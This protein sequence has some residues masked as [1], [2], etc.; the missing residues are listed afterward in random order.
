[1]YSTLP[2]FEVQISKGKLTFDALSNDMITNTLD[3]RTTYLPADFAIG[4]NDTSLS[5]T[6]SAGPRV[7]L[8]VIPDLSGF[9]S[10]GKSLHK[11]LEKRPTRKS[12]MGAPLAFGAHFVGQHR[13]QSSSL[14]TLSLATHS[15]RYNRYQSACEFLKVRTRFSWRLYVRSVSKPRQ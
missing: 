6:V 13:A 9:G 12:M 1:M 15:I 2:G 11:S 8:N 10:I 4:K 14:L 5:F 7:K 3:V